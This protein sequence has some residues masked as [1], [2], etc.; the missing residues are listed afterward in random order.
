MDE[1]REVEHLGIRFKDIRLF[2][3]NNKYFLLKTL[4]DYRKDKMLPYG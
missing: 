1:Y 2:L 3:N 4:N